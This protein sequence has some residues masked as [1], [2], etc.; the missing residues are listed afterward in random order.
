MK[1]IIF[2][3]CFLATCVYAGDINYVIINPTGPFTTWTSTEVKPPKGG[4]YLDA[5][6]HTTGYRVTASTAE[7]NSVGGT[8]PEYTF[9]C[10]SSN[11]QYLVFN[12]ASNDGNSNT[13]YY[14]YT[15]TSVGGCSYI[16]DVS[17]LVGYPNSEGQQPEVRWDNSG[18]H[19]SWLY[20]RVGKTLKYLDCSDWS[21]HT[22]H[23]F[24]TNMTGY[25]ASY[26]IMM[27]DEGDCSEDSRYWTFIWGNS[28]TNTVAVLSYDKTLDVMVSSV[29]AGYDG[30]NSVYVSK[31]GSYVITSCVNWD[32]NES[33]NTWS[34]T[35]IR[36]FNN[37]SNSAAKFGYYH[38]KHMCMAYDKQGNDVIV[39]EC[40]TKIYGDTYQMIKMSNG[41]PYPLIDQGDM[42]WGVNAQWHAPGLAKKGWVF[43]SNYVLPTDMGSWSDNQIIAFELDEAH[44]STTTVTNRIWRV[45]ANQSHTGAAGEYYITQP[46]P[47]IT[48]DGAYLYWG[49]NWRDNTKILEV[50]RINMPTNWYTDLGGQSG[51]GT[52]STSN[53]NGVTLKGITLH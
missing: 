34:S 28:N 47:S 5:N 53:I 29:T 41:N 20:F 30:I 9:N 37:L 23:D 7:H 15:T 21:V 22:V 6:A 11:N 24:S 32:G 18:S 40:S 38:S 16:K 50:Y 42:G 44:T 12:G 13:G 25:D 10:Q 39:A 43:Y 52:T 1:K 31:S 51:G 17:T 26:Y 19:P 36:P 3:L 27:G 8:V 14:I 49:A 46:N 48:T 45:A 2:I 33:A 4:T 35:Y